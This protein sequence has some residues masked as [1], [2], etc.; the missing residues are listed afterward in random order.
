MS[1]LLLGLLL[2]LSTSHVLLGEKI[3]EKNMT[4]TMG[5]LDLL[6]YP[7]LP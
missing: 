2:L 3:Y 7:N 5:E 4:S 1:L 6:F